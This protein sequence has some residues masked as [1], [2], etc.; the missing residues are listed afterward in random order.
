MLLHKKSNVPKPNMV[1]W[2]REREGTK[3]RRGS[4]VWLLPCHMIDIEKIISPNAT[5]W[6]KITEYV[7][8]SANSLD[9]KRKK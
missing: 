7:M 2:W 5:N 1:G 6:M 9:L 4:L 3:P 8:I